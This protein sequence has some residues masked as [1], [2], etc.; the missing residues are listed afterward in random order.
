MC[1]DIVF[2]KHG[3]ILVRLLSWHSTDLYAS[4]VW[5]SEKQTQVDSVTEYIA[6]TNKAWLLL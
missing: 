4:Q 2:L 6:V 1:P 5:S 3:E